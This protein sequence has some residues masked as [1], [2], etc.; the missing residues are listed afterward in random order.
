MLANVFSPTLAQFTFLFHLEFFLSCFR[1]ILS[2]V[3]VCSCLFQFSFTVCVLGQES[4]IQVVPRTSISLCVKL[5]CKKCLDI[6][7]K[8]LLLCTC[9]CEWM[10]GAWRGEA[11]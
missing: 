10:A 6:E 8:S 9:V 5:R 2:E 4:D 7:K 11:L 1:F 3:P